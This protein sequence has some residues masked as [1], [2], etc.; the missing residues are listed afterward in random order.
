[1]SYSDATSN[2]RPLSIFVVED[3]LWYGELLSHHLGLNPDN[4]VRRFEGAQ[5]L[6]DALS[7]KP[8]LITLD[9]RLPDVK[10]DAL[11]R[12]IKSLLPETNVIVISG[13]EDVATAL[14][15]LRE[16]V[17]DYLVKNDETR[18]RLWNAVNKIRRNIEL[19][20]EVQQLRQ[21][22]D[23]Q[24]DLQHLMIG[25]CEAM[26]KVFSL[27]MRAASTNINVSVTGETG[28]GKELVA[29]AAHYNSP[30]SRKPF[31]AVNMA[32]IP[33]ICSRANCLGMRREHLQEP[34]PHVSEKLKKPVAVRCSSMRLQIWTCH[35][36]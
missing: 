28:T 29:K 16:G 22:I 24:Y 31:V 19:E 5:E 13:Q 30:R 20:T 7:E 2:G 35:C 12:K 9:Y 33:A 36:R 17:F 32:S 15:L 3:D 11:F 26:K 27:I 18:E 14:N 8:D 10:G 25:N 23:H 6:L 21:Q 4:K 34:S 1:M